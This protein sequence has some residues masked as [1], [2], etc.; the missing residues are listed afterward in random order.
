MRPT[1]PWRDRHQACLRGEVDLR[2]E[3]PGNEVPLEDIPLEGVGC[4]AL[5]LRLN[6]VVGD[7]PAR[8]CQESHDQ[9]DKQVE[10][11]G[12]DNHRDRRASVRIHDFR[13]RKKHDRCQSAE[14]LQRPLLQLVQQQPATVVERLE[15][16]LD[17]KTDL[18]DGEKQH[19]P[20]RTWRDV[21]ERDST[22]HSESPQHQ[23]GFP[24]V[25]ASLVLCEDDA[26]ARPH[27][28]VPQGSGGVRSPAEA[29][30]QRRQREAPE[31]GCEATDGSERGVATKRRLHQ[32]PRV[33]ICATQGVA[34]GEGEQLLK[35]GGVDQH[36][37]S[38]EDTRGVRPEH[39]H[40][41][42]PVVR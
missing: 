39:L 42:L 2:S 12:D 26:E 18:A 4:L 32:H 36:H 24:V 29:A 1:A 14:C 9:A 31:E 37:G 41:L 25:E 16:P 22:H 13:H 28:E 8:E 27:G 17:E 19:E 35:Q 7:R 23:R 30:S 15:R 6:D 20:Q 5:Q 38:Q 3:V 34:A 33:P 21:G 40:P 10:M 11:G